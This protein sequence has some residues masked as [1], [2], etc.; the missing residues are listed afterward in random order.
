MKKIIQHIA[1][2]L[3]RPYSYR[4]DVNYQIMLPFILGFVVFLILYFLKP[5]S[6]GLVEN[7]HI[8]YFGG[9]GIITTIIIL[10][11]FFIVNPIFPNYFSDATWTVKKEILTLFTII[12]VVGTLAWFYHKSVAFGN[13]DTNS[14]TLL[15]FIK[16]SF[17]IGIFPVILYVYLSEMFLANDR[18]N[19]AKKIKKSISLKRKKKKTDLITLFSQNKKNQ[20]TFNVNDLVYISS[21]G[22]YINLFFIDAGNGIS[23]KI[24]RLQL[25]NIEE[26]LIEY[27]EF[28]RCHKSYIVNTNYVKDISGNARAYYLHLS[29]NNTVPVSR[30]FKKEDLLKLIY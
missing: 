9:Y 20:V 28:V 14:F 23:E 22:N 16:Y 6:L 27:T 4:E 13:Y 11:F 24:M 26:K 17:S 12:I 5:F 1:E 8:L 21:E 25:K 30:K 19:V 7:N 29:S 18:N 2:W 10:I 15:H 3:N